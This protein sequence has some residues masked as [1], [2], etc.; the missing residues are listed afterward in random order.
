MIKQRRMHRSRASLAVPLLLGVCACAALL[1][2][3]TAHAFVSGQ[4]GRRLVC[5]QAACGTSLA[6]VFQ[7]NQHRATKSVQ[8]AAGSPDAGKQWTRNGALAQIGV[9]LLVFLVGGFALPP[10]LKYATICYRSKEYTRNYWNNSMNVKYAESKGMTR[11]EFERQNFDDPMCEEAGVLLGRF[12][13]FLA[14]EDHQ[15][16]DIPPEKRISKN[17]EFQFYW[18]RTDENR[19]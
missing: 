16:Y 1:S 17:T 2:G 5:G 14:G 10:D 13:K 6:H 9:F 18:Q 8:L 3:R 4:R 7:T 19:S 12:Q 11:E 15:R